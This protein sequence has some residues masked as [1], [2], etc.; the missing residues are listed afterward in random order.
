MENE[1]SLP[2][3]ECPGKKEISQ[4]SLS[5]LPAGVLNFQEAIEAVCVA[6]CHGGNPSPGGGG[7]RAM[8]VGCGM[9]QLRGDKDGKFVKGSSATLVCVLSSDRGTTPG[10]QPV[11]EE[12]SRAH[13]KEEQSLLPFFF[14]LC[15]KEHTSLKGSLL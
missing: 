3:S 13:G 1:M 15:L 7:M 14:L 4:G 12:G 8:L 11:S 10:P 2:R 5:L 6:W 9:N